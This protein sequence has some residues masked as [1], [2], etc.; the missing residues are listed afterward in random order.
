METLIDWLGFL[1]AWLL[2]AGPIYQAALE[3]QDQDIEVER[4]RATGAKVGEQPKVSVWWWL[5]PPVKI[6]LARQKSAEYR[7]KYVRALLKED[8]ES[9]ITFMNKATGWLFVAFG[10]LCIAI[11]ETY[12]LTEQMEWDTAILCALVVFMALLSLGNLIA[13]MKR[14]RKIIDNLE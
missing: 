3:L 9:M 2:F 11:K 5:L 12:E 6:V 10:G 1:G 4:I 13:R 8:A 14:T 7:K